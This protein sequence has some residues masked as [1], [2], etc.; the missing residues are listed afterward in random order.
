MRL[1]SW[2]KK[3]EEPALHGFIENCLALGQSSFDHADIYG[4]Y[5]TEADFGAVLKGNSALRDKLQLITKCGIGYVAPNRPENKIKH[6]NSSKD[7][8]IKSVEASLKALNTDRID[9][10]LIHRPDFLM[11]P[12]EVSITID[13]LKLDGKVLEFGVSNFSFSQFQMLNS[14]IK[15]FTHQ[16][17][18]H[19]LHLDAFTNGTLDQCLENGIRP[20]AWSPLAGGR[21][22]EKNNAYASRILE[23]LVNL[24]PKYNASPD[25]LVYAWL[26]KHPS[27]ILPVLGTTK[28]ERVEAALAALKIDMDRQDWYKIWTAATGKK[29]A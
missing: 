7:Y 27:E 2:G 14:R 17:E 24:S 21:L 8:I 19:P 23:C 29:V 6:Y 16:V 28:I 5:T 11:D 13:Q 4:D 22:F 20:M 10:L 1:G 25:Q 18:I 3:L 9:V 12:D 26:M 15:L